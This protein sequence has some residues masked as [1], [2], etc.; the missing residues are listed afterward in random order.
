M[1]NEVYTVQHII[2][3]LLPK[4]KALHLHRVTE[5]HFRHGIGIQQDALRQAFAVASAGTPLEYAALVIDTADV[6]CTCPCG[7]QQVLT[8]HDL[9]MCQ[10][11]CPRCGQVH[12]IE[13]AHDIELLYVVGEAADAET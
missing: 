13:R 11:T 12:A 8:A 2:A 1:T 7:F 4:L 6:S 3:G 10:F 9:E 5:A